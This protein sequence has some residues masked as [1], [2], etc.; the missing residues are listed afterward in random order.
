MAAFWPLFLFGVALVSK[1]LLPLGSE[2]AHNS[3]NLAIWRAYYV[4]F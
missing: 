1:E 3:E 4:Y 2:E